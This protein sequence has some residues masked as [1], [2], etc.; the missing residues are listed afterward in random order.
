MLDTYKPKYFNFKVKP[1]D[2]IVEEKLYQNPENEGHVFYVLFE[3][4]FQNTF[5]ILDYLGKNLNL[6]RKHFGIWGLKDKF[7]ITRQW[8]SIYKRTLN[9]RWGAKNFLKILSK[10]AKIL[11]TSWW[12]QLLKVWDNKWNLFFIRLRPTVKA[13]KVKKSF[14]KEQVALVLKD[15]QKND[16]PNYFGIQRF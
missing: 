13:K 1:Q 9:S 11:K 5:D 3:K 16:F 10:R 7:W 6:Q 14:L 8:I 2:F 12:K 15:I 4:K